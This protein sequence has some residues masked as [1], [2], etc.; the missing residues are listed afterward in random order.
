M[1][2]KI[3]VSKEQVLNTAFEMTREDGFAALT[4]R[5]L[6][7]RLA[8]STQ[9]IF[10]AYENMDTLKEDL[11]YK[12]EGFF[13]ERMEMSANGFEPSYLSMSL[14]YIELAQREYNLFALLSGA[15][16]YE[17][18]EYGV[19]L[20]KGNTEDIIRSLPNADELDREEG[21]NLIKLLWIFTHGLAVLI[22][23]KRIIIDKEGI[24]GMLERAYEGFYMAQKY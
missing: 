16:Q 17:N 8:S 6:A 22:A 19:Y 12:C 15:E 3:R 13:G 5:K 23:G 14:K 21:E 4:A 24:V 9:P 20:Q 11:F 2:P 10:R 1:P 7:E 18:N